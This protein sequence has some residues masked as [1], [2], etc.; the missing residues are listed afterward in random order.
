MD[1]GDIPMKMKAII[2]SLAV[3]LLGANMALATSVSS[4]VNTTPDLTLPY[5]N[6]FQ[7]T[8]AEY[9]LVDGGTADVLDVGDVLAGHLIINQINTTTIGGGTTNNELTAYFEAK[10]TSKASTG[11]GFNY[12]FGAN[13]ALG[14]MVWAYDDSSNNATLAT[15]STLTDGNLWAVLGTTDGDTSWNAFTDTDDITTLAT[16]VTSDP[17]NPAHGYFNFYLDTLLN[18][19]GLKFNDVGTHTEWVGGGSFY[20]IPNGANSIYAIGDQTNIKANVSAVPEPASMALLGIG[21][22]GLAFVSRR[23]KE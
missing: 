1:K 21:L 13:N 16:E 15:P 9:L 6:T 19:T 2:V 3:L 10:V 8:S 23:R 12:T 5:N 18:N 14:A 11:S 20:G 4:N 22:L 17:G 7:D